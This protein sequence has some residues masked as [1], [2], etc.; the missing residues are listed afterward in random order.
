MKPSDKVV[1]INDDWSGCWDDPRNY[2]QVLP[3]K[4]R[5]YTVKHLAI[6]RN[7]EIMVIIV[8]CE[9]C[10]GEGGFYPQRFALLSDIKRKHKNSAHQNTKQ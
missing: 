4:G 2:F 5:V 9:S 6:A 8:G 7:G 1:C 10:R 3:Q